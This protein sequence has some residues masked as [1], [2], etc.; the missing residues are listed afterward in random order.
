MGCWGMTRGPCHTLQWL[1]LCSPRSSLQPVRSHDLTPHSSQTDLLSI[2]HV[3]GSHGFLGSFFGPSPFAG[4]APSPTSADLAMF[5]HHDSAHVTSAKLS[6]TIH[7]TV[8]QI[9]PLGPP[10]FFLST[11][12]PREIYL[13]I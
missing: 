10:A 2:L 12:H 9:I 11:Y 6:H 13:F 7:P 3:P 8:S 5:C 1:S 4:D